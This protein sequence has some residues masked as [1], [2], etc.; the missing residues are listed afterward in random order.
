MSFRSTELASPDITAWGDMLLRTSSEH[1]PRGNVLA[2]Q[3]AGCSAGD[4]RK[5]RQ[6]AA[7]EIDRSLAQ[8]AAEKSAGSRYGSA[9]VA[10]GAG[11]WVETNVEQ[12]LTQARTM[13]RLSIT[14]KSSPN[15]TMHT[16]AEPEQ[17]TL[18]AARGGGSDGIGEGGSGSSS[19]NAH[20]SFAPAAVDATA[21]AASSS[22]AASAAGG[23]GHSGH[24]SSDAGHGDDG[25]DD[26]GD[27]DGDD[28]ESEE[29]NGAGRA[30]DGGSDDQEEEDREDVERRQRAARVAQAQ[31]QAQ[32]QYG[33]AT[34]IPSHA[35]ERAKWNE[36]VLSRVAPPTPLSRH[37]TAG[38]PGDGLVRQSASP[39]TPAARLRAL[40][41]DD[42][43]PA[44][45]AAP[46]AAAAAAGEAQDGREEGRPRRASPS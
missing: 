23:C 28:G 37:A 19:G 29:G 4:S 13:N 44:A 31:R 5:T 17:E 41:P 8:T 10:Q 32:R 14:S 1:V 39:I 21:A 16:A 2:V 25:D 46:Q 22:A 42:G 9:W 45:L 38:I 27:D 20:V 7:T 34:K 3:Q 15:L 6:D 33:W 36:V 24:S 40:F 30:E 35:G 26:G 18:Q 43:H 11:Q 12:M